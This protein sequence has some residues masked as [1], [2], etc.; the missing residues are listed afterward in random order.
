[1]S[2][3]T[4]SVKKMLESNVIR[5][6]HGGFLFANDYAPKTLSE[7]S[8]KA[9]KD[10]LSNLAKKRTVKVSKKPKENGESYVFSDGS[11]IIRSNNSDVTTREKFAWE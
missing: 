6:K 9:V 1:M 7:D 10:F 3:A 8:C 11:R 2:L 4:E 5:K